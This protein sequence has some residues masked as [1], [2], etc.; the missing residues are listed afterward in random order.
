MTWYIAKDRVSFNIPQSDGRGSHLH[1]PTGKD[2]TVTCDSPDCNAFFMD[3]NER[4]VTARRQLE[5]E[6]GTS[7]CSDKPETR[8]KT[9]AECEEEQELLEARAREEAA[10]QL[11]VSRQR[12]AA[13][14]P[15]RR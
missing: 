13:L 15:I 11:E 3:E 7:V 5:G 8:P 10:V 2:Y 14:I 1:E 9:V 12:R 6:N 4:R